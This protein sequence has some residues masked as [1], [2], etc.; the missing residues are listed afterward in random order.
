M[1]LAG[2][3]PGSWR[4]EARTARGQRG[5]GGI[6]P[7]EHTGLL[8][9]QDGGRARPWIWFVGVKEGAKRA[10]RGATL[11]P[12]EGL[13]VLT[14]LVACGDGAPIRLDVAPPEGSRS[15]VVLIDEL[16]EF[17]R[18]RDTR[19]AKLLGL[20]GV[21][22]EVR[23]GLSEVRDEP[24]RI[25]VL[26]SPRNPLEL[27]FVEGP[28]ATSS[29]GDACWK[30]EAPTLFQAFVEDGRPGAFAEVPDLDAAEVS[31]ACLEGPSSACVQYRVRVTRVGRGGPNFAL[32]LD[33]HR[34]AFSMGTY[35]V[36]TFDTRTE[37]LEPWVLPEGF[38]AGAVLPLEGDRYWFGGTQGALWQGRIEPELDV[39]PV[40]TSSLG[41][42]IGW[43]AGTADGASLY[44]L[45]Y[46]GALELYQGG[47]WTVVHRFPARP[48]SNSC[49][50]L[51]MLPD[52]E[53]LAARGSSGRLVS[54]REGRVRELEISDRNGLCSVTELPG[55]GVFI[56]TSDG[57]IL[58]RAGA[59]VWENMGPS[60]LSQ[61]INNLA[62]MG[63]GFVFSGQRGFFGSWQPRGGF[64]QH[65][66]TVRPDAPGD[67]F[68][69]VPV[70]AEV[71]L[72]GTSE[73]SEVSNAITRFT[74]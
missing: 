6:A 5:G 10:T 59:E 17:G 45:S 74:P 26:F 51:L 31:C 25:S 27:G 22:S 72:F 56:T 73:S 61:A 20:E 30:P 34:L 2:A 11:M 54:V 41:G 48:A 69:A 43:M 28:L 63:E 53:L 40:S 24:L 13:I 23:T 65:M 9:A 57:Q 16:D 21:E 19:E 7:G 39:M 55:L 71:F 14:G 60:G 32:R 38:P 49:G 66:D 12:K 4:S 33:E 62:P 52:G 44:T 68:F 8:R 37:A 64:C 46:E 29:G 58:R 18:C 50:G 42:E 67:A 70:G 47:Q 36:Y 15:A 35:L 1:V 3:G